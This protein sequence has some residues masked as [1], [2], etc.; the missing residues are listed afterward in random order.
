MT[1]PTS[2]QNLYEQGFSPTSTFLSETSSCEKD[3]LVEK[4]GQHTFLF[5]PTLLLLTFLVV[6]TPTGLGVTMIFWFFTHTHQGFM[7]LWREGAFLLDE[8][9]EFEGDFKAA[10]LSGLTITTAAVSPVPAE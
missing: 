1:R 5:S 10:R 3:T 4:N 2:L 8:G 7:G 6:I 9:I